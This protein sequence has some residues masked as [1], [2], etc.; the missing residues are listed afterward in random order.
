[1][2]SEVLSYVCAGFDGVVVRLWM[3]SRE[4]GLRDNVVNLATFVFLVLR[5]R[6]KVF[7]SWFFGLDTADPNAGAP[8]WGHALCII[9]LRLAWLSLV[10]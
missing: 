8:T 5:N 1:M 3:P 9:G 10:I 7:H 6:H 4:Q 2:R